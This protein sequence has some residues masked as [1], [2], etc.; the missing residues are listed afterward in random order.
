MVGIYKITSPT[1]KVYIGQSWDIDNR[2][3]GHKHCNHGYNDLLRNSVKKYGFDNH[4]FEVIH[5]LPEDID[6][7]ILDDYEIFYWNAYKDCGFKMLNV[8]YPGSKGKHSEETKQKMRKPK[9][10]GFGEK[11]SKI[12]KGTKR[13]QSADRVMGEKNPM[14]RKEVVSKIS[15]KNHYKAKKVVGY[16]KNGNMIGIWD[17]IAAAA[18]ELKI[19]GA[20]IVKCC[21]GIIKTTSK[22]TFNYYTDHD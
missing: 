20:G 3:S 14:K 9:P 5:E 15:G 21:K 4:I 19:S 22:C 13:P 1:N 18:K 16:D 11:T 6:Q 8:R 17:T 12:Q 2:K 10:M 7:T